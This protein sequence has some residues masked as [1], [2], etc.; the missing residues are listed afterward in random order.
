M[1]SIEELQAILDNDP[2]YQRL[3]QGYESPGGI[4][5]T[6]K[7]LGAYGPQYGARRKELGVEI[8]EGYITDAETGQ[9]NKEEGVP[10]WAWALPAIG[11][12]PWALGLGGAGAA[13]AGTAG[14]T[15]AGAGTAAAAGGVMGTLGKVG[16]WIG[17]GTDVLGALGGVTSG[18]AKGSAD[19]RLAE[20]LQMLGY[21]N[22]QLQG[23]RDQFGAGLQ[24]AQFNREGQDRTRKSEMLMALL[25]GMQ[26]LK[27]TP[28]NPKIAAAMGNVAGGARPSALTGN[29]DALMALLAQPQ[30]QA[31]TY[32]KPTL[33]EMPKAGAMENILG[34]VGLGSN[35]LGALG[36][37]FN[38]PK[39]QVDP[40]K[41]YADQGYATGY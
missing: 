23:A 30:T 27:L 37:L 25:S 31:P 40:M 4:L 12:A 21:G 5:N 3:V 33:P 34:G 28:G 9:I 2:E 14:A 24:G 20:A 16:D 41:Q 10:G 22:Q 38:K 7:Y 13:G 1:A 19:Q 29:R 32:Q 36:G 39:P 35:I 6:T 11:V 15:G 8:P 26:D 17:K 18:A